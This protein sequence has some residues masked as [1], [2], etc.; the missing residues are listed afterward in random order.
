MKRLVGM[1][2][3]GVRFYTLNDWKGAIGFESRPTLSPLQVAKLGRELEPKIAVAMD[4]SLRR[5]AGYANLELQTPKEARFHRIYKGRHSARQD[6]VILHLYDLSASDDKNAEAKAQ[7]EFEALHRAAT[8]SLGT[9]DS[10]FV[11][12]SA[13]LRGRDVLLYPG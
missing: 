5:L 3:R 8:V 11:S 12:R 7:R 9:A 2:V 10:G 4:G 1:E 13:G 6:P